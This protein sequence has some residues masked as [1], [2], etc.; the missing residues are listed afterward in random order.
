L[1]RYFNAAATV[2]LVYDFL[3]TFGDE[4]ERIWKDGT[5]TGAKVLWVGVSINKI[6]S[7]SSGI[8]EI[9]IGHPE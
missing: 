4:K 5:W 1:S 3:L 6:I 9:E 8:L 7:A 2:I